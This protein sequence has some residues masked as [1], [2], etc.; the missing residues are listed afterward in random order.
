LQRR[1]VSPASFASFACLA[2]VAAVVATC[3]VACQGQGEGE[4]CST[5]D[6][7]GGPLNSSGAYASPYSAGSSDCSGSNVC[8]PAA[9]LGGAAADY[10][11]SAHDPSFG[12]CCP[13]NRYAGDPTTICAT[14]PSPPGSDAAPPPADSGSSDAP[15]SDGSPET[16]GGDA[17]TPS[18][19]AAADAPVEPG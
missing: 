16:D 7:P 6:D 13:V 9:S 17:A 5:T 14:Q 10:A 11:E 15:A 2:L 1:L 3:V 4:R 12:I 19:D 18:T 8:Y